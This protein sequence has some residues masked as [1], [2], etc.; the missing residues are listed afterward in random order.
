MPPLINPINAAAATHDKLH[1]RYPEAKIM[2]PATKIKTWSHSWGTGSVVT[3]ALRNLIK[4]NKLAGTSVVATEN[5]LT[6]HNIQNGI[7]GFS[8]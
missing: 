1:V 5:I 6:M 2:Q 4:A 3:L 7:D 8:K